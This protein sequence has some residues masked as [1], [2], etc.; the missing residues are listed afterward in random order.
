MIDLGFTESLSEFTL[1]IKKVDTDVIIVSLYV[2]D[3][4]V[5]GNN[6]K[7]IEKFKKEIKNVFEMTDL[8]KMSFFLGMEVQQQQNEI[9]ICQQKYAKELPTKFSM[10]EGKPTATP[11]N[12]KQKFYKENGADKVDEGG[13]RSW[14]PN[15]PDCN[16]ARHKACSK[17]VVKIHALC[18]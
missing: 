5:T 15:V 4:L 16:K 3:L 7:L 8:G 6:E 11:M 2:D 12:Q 13:Y 14:L 17:F 18:Y 1:Y 10:E 9:F